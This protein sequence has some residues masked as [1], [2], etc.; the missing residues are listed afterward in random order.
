M[1]LKGFRVAVASNTLVRK[2]IGCSSLDELITKIVD[3]FTNAS[4]FKL[5]KLNGLKQQI[6]KDNIKVFSEDGTEIDDNEYLMDYL[7]NQSLL[8]VNFGVEKRK[9]MTSEA[10]PKNI[11]DHLLTSIRWSGGMNSVYTEVLEFMQQ[12]FHEKWN[13]MKAMTDLRE[14]ESLTCLSTR[15]EHPDWFRDIPNSSKTKEEFMRKN[16][17]SRVRGYLSKAEKQL[18]EA[19][20][21]SC[22]GSGDI[23]YTQ[24]ETLLQGFR[25]KLRENSYHGHYFDRSSI[26]DKICDSSGM[27][28]CEGK[29][30]LT[31][32]SYGKDT[33]FINPYASQEARILFST[34]NLDHVIEKSRSIV[35]TVIK[36]L[37]KP[38]K[39][40]AL[41]LDYFYSLLFT[42]D[43]LKLVHVVCHDKQEHASMKCDPCKLWT[44]S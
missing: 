21:I 28:T 29:F 13:S 31:T 7:P 39:G 11:F 19:M 9:S 27:F 10:E 43:N 4:D 25:K 37:S 44:K 18:K 24:A 15:A 20:D 26:K 42:R 23:T 36:C 32:C 8:I 2:G 3:K 33:H 40:H 30:N 22:R 38:K 14:H 34:W 6:Y 17:A 16:C 1:G 5:N 41:N 12:D 35:P